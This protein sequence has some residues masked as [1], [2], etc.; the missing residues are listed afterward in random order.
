MAKKQ[1]ES[2]DDSVEFDLN[3]QKSRELS[4][5]DADPIDTD[6]GQPVFDDIAPRFTRAI[7]EAAEEPP[8]KKKPVAKDDDEEDEDLDESDDET[9]EPDEAELPELDDEDEPEDEEALNAGMRKRLARERRLRDEERLNNRELKDRLSKLERTM[10]LQSNDELYSR[11]VGNLNREWAEVRAKLKQ[12]KEDGETD[13]E[14][15]LTDKLIEIKADLKQKEADHKRAKEAAKQQQEAPASTVVARKATQ[16]IRKHPSFTSDPVFAEFV[17]AIDRKL[18]KQ[19]LDPET[20]DFYRTLDKEVSKRYPEEYPR[21]KAAK[22]AVPPTLNARR[23]GNQ[24]PASKTVDFATQ[25]G[26]VR[27]TRRQLDNMSKFG[28]DPRNP[29][30]VRDYVLNNRTKV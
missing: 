30:D 20:D 3:S 5:N 8:R 24:K 12:A 22:P 27:V 23:E 15:E 7:E 6:T 19:G 21:R 10:E 17:K 1:F 28:L 26:K 11:D 13:V 29:N 9:D 4:G 2:D 18:A 14:L 25:N 16:W